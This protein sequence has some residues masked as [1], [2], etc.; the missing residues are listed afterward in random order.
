LNMLTLASMVRLGK[1][2]EN[3]MVDLQPKSLKLVAR[4]QRLIERLGSVS[5]S[6]A[7]RLYRQAKGHVKPAIV[8][9]KRN[10]SFQKAVRLLAD[11]DGFL[12]KAL[13]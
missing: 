9:A 7:A 12:R 2:Y 11:A 13:K 1:V 6:D 10:V 4:G 3:W 8:M 5:K